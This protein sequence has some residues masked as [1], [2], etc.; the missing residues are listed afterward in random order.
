MTYTP[1]THFSF[2]I[3]IIFCHSLDFATQC[4]MSLHIFYNTFWGPCC[5]ILCVGSLQTNFLTLDHILYSSP[6]HCFLLYLLYF[7]TVTERKNYLALGPLQ[8]WLRAELSSGL[9]PAPSPL[10]YINVLS[11]QFLLFYAERT[12]QS[13][14]TKKFRIF[15]TIRQLLRQE[16][17]KWYNLS[18]SQ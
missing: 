2:Q 1:T 4:C 14:Q 5:S 8:R 12:L 11:V 16:S 9:P 15:Q 3:Y 10:T 6:S 17:C 18:A 13:D 7:V